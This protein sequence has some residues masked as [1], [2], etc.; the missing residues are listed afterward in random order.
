MHH[1]RTFGDV[2]VGDGIEVEATYEVTREEMV[3]FAE[4]YDP[5]PFHVDEEAAA[6]S[7]F[8]ELIASGWQTCAIAMRLLV[9]GYLNESGAQGA[10]G[11]D[12]LRWYQPVTAGDVLHLEGETVGKEPWS[13]TMGL[14]RSRAELFDDDDEMVMSYVGLVLFPKRHA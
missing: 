12:D 9:D 6:D 7:H 2:E 10:V 14:V 13:E 11:V 1:P 3:A 4:R 8:G 5:Q